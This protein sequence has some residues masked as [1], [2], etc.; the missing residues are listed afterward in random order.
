Q[1]LSYPVSD[2]SF[3]ASGRMLLAERGISN[4][5]IPQ[6]HAS[7]VLEYACNGGCWQLTNPF[8][9]GDGVAMMNCEGGVDYDRFSYTGG[10]LGRVWASGDA[11]HFGGS[12]TDYIYGYQ[13]FRPTG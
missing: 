11:L 8:A 6:A 3:G 7:R 5:T 13:G 9:V 4:E 1:D 12:Y 10:P 2:I